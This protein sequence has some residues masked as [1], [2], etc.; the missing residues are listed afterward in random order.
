MGKKR[1]PTKKSHPPVWLSVPNQKTKNGSHLQ[2]DGWSV[3]QTIHLHFDGGCQDGNPGGIP[4]YGWQLYALLPDGGTIISS[5]YDVCRGF[6]FFE[7]TN[8]TAEWS[9]VVAALQWMKEN[10]VACYQ[11]Q[12]IGDSMLIINQLAGR[13]ANKKDHLKKLGHL[14]SDSLSY[15]CL[16]KYSCRWIPRCHNALCDEL[17]DR[18]YHEKK[19][20]PDIRPD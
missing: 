12:V 3:Y 8:N 15:V 9:G 2:A 14:A 13:W 17:A 10:K 18:A 1:K 4:T 7:R 20:D 19:D 6:K 11:L 5:G 16:N